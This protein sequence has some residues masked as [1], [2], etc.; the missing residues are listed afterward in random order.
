MFLV[1]FL[2]A[3]ISVIS[4]S[5]GVLPWSKVS[6]LASVPGPILLI[7]V[8]DLAFTTVPSLPLPAIA[9]LWPHQPASHH[10]ILIA[11]LHHALLLPENCL[12]LPLSL[13]LLTSLLIGFALVAK[14]VDTRLSLSPFSSSL[15]SSLPLSRSRSLSDSEADSLQA[16]PIPN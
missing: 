6:C 14:P 12:P 3:R 10:F 9:S 7:G 2:R 15:A 13:F 16:S 11:I 8:G 5:R 4:G 1:Y